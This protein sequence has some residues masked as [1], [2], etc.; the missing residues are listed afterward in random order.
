MHTVGLLRG[1][2][3]TFDILVPNTV[4][5]TRGPRETHNLASRSVLLWRAPDTCVLELMLYLFDLDLHNFV[6][7]VR[8]LVCA[9]C[10]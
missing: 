8:N 3:V 1:Y 9:I 2:L 4:K 6:F 5:G 7:H 10:R